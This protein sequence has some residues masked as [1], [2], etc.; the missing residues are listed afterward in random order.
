MLMQLNEPGFNFGLKY[1]FAGKIK[2]ITI[3]NCFHLIDSFNSWHMN[4]I[5][6]HPPDRKIA[7]GS[8]YFNRGQLICL[9]Q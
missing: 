6:Y 8:I 2:T 5:D 1:F 7:T 9:W 4:Y 3:Y